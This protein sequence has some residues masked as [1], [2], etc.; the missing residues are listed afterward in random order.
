[1]H[2]KCVS[3]FYYNQAYWIYKYLNNRNIF[4]KF[5]CNIHP[6]DGFQL[7]VPEQYLLKVKDDLWYIERILLELKD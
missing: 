3:S 1:M 4:Y 2:Y 5:D 6:D 7:F